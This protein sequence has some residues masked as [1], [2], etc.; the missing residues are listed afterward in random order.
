MHP[1]VALAHGVIR[2]YQVTLSGLIG[3]QC[4]HLPTC[5]DY[6]DEAMQRHGFWAGGWMGFARLCRCQPFGTQ[7]LDFVPRE[8]PQDGAWY[9]PWRYGRWRSTCVDPFRCDAVPAPA[10]TVPGPDAPPRQPGLPAGSA[11]VSRRPDD[12]PPDLP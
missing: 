11:G 3:R 12:D 2:L 1:G 4:R 6:M 5:S 8:L 10:G 7:G 9:R